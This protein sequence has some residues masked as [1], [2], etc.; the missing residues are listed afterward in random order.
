VAVEKN[1]PALL[2]DNV[3]L[4]LE[5]PLRDPD[6]LYA[7]LDTTACAAFIQE[8]RMKCT[9]AN[10]LHRKSGARDAPG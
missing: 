1:A 4:P 6:F 9:N 5:C 8:N 3:N 2:K 7:A 10:R